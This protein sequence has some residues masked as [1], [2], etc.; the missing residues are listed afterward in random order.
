M[1]RFKKFDSEMRSVFC[2]PFEICN[3]L[4]KLTGPGNGFE[5][6][7]LTDV[8]CALCV[9]RKEKKFGDHVL[10]RVY[11]LRPKTISQNSTCTRLISIKELKL[12]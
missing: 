2:E 6:R 3:S 1:Q 5:E 4:P 10:G 12:V 7:R 9:E 8:G 11:F